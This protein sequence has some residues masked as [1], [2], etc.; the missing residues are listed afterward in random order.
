MT[1]SEIYF[2][3]TCRCLINFLFISST[4]ESDYLRINS[5]Y[6]NLLKI[7]N[8]NKNYI[9]LLG[10]IQPVGFSSETADF[11]INKDDY[12]DIFFEYFSV[13]TLDVDYF[14]SFNKL[15]NKI[16][17]S[18]NLKDI[19]MLLIEGKE[20][21]IVFDS[22]IISEIGKLNLN[23]KKANLLNFLNLEFNYQI[24][25]FL[26]YKK[27]INSY[28]SYF[29]NQIKDC[30]INNKFS[31]CEILESNNYSIF[32]MSLNSVKQTKNAILVNKNNIRGSKEVI[33]FLKNYLLQRNIIDSK[34]TLIDLSRKAVNETI[35]LYQKEYR[36]DLER[37]FLNKVL[38]RWL[39]NEFYEFK[40]AKRIKVNNKVIPYI[41]KL[42]SMI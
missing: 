27:E 34:D 9:E 28:D 14:F 10:V 17:L 8:V 23:L 39:A 25:Y 6:E 37:R 18:F 1:E 40:N 42:K 29:F 35:R 2:E 24:G 13:N 12:K 11:L 26:Y 4:S 21:S 19:N 7:N 16:F 30:L 38:N 22:N 5:Y 3:L 32:N 41:Y 31:I 33:N 20:Y 36:V 15:I